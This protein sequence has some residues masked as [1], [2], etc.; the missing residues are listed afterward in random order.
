[1]SGCNTTIETGSRGGS[2][3]PGNIPAINFS[4][5]P[6]LS[7]AVMGPESTCEHQEIR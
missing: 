2:I 6:P 7:Y 5:R 1:M 3:V 4:A